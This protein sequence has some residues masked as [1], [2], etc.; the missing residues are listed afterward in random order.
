VQGATLD[1]VRAPIRA[2]LT[3]ERMQT[4]RT[5]YLNTLRAKTAVRI[6][7]EP[8][9]QRVATADSPAR[10]PENA[11]IELIEFSDFQCPFC[12]RADP[13]F[14][15]SLATYG[16]RIRFVYRHYPLPNHPNA[17]PAAEAAA[18]AG[19]QGK[20]WAFH[21]RTLHNSDAAHRRRPETARRGI[22]VDTAKFNACV[23]GTR[24]RR[25]STPTCAPARKPGS[26]A[27]RR[28][29]STADR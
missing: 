15:R 4:I 26:T 11:P 28:S 25:A 1:Q 2:Y 13:S 8:P 6:N 12:L 7:L 3:Q 17:R 14:A 20:F 16:D 19:D 23:D 10:G 5:E 9:R 18:C 24:P 22:G 27:R 29:S 21:D